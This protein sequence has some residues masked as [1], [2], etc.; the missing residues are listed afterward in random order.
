MHII[1]KEF[2]SDIVDAENKGSFISYNYAKVIYKYLYKSY[3]K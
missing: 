3:N 1:K 2:K